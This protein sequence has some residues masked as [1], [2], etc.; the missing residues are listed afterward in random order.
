MATP[1]HFQIINKNQ[2]FKTKKSSPPSSGKRIEQSKCGV[3][4]NTYNRYS[5]C[6]SFIFNNIFNFTLSD[7]TI[8]TSFFLSSLFSFVLPS[9]LY[10]YFYL[11]SFFKYAHILLSLPRSRSTKVFN[12]GSA[13]TSHP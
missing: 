8:F 5:K 4:N 10:F 2:F 1:S 3:H 11:S 7:K 12:H 9:P 6:L 13:L